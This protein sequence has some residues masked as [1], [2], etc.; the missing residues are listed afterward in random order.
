MDPAAALADL[1]E[2]SGQV[3]HAIMLGHDGTVLASTLPEADRAQG[4]ARLVRDLLAEAQAAPGSGREPLVQLQ[5]AL[6]DG[7][8]FVA[9]D[10]HRIAAAVTVPFPTPGLVFY[11]LKNALRQ[12]AGEAAAPSPRPWEGEAPGQEGSD[13]QG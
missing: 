12:V 6:P 3:E 2:V 5:V 10:E 1:T 13:G 4:V 11:D 7:C 9:Q 8:V